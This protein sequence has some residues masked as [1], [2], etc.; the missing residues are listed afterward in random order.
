MHEERQARNAKVE[1]SFRK[2]MAEEAGC[3]SRQRGCI[4]GISEMREGEGEEGET[5]STPRRA[6]PLK[7][8]NPRSPVESCRFVTGIS[9]GAA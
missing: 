6:A 1:A 4:E 2:V 9:V 3:K 8:E 7:Q 5:G